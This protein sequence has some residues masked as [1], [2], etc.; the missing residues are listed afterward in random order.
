MSIPIRNLYYMLAY[1][2][3]RDDF[4]GTTKKVGSDEFPE[5]I[6]F[7]ATALAKSCAVLLRRGF[8]RGYLEVVEETSIPRG[9]IDFG[10]TI[11]K[12]TRRNG[13]VVCRVEE[14]T[15]DVLHNQILKTVIAKLIRTSDVRKET[16]KE[17]FKVLERMPGVQEISLDR[18]VFNRVQ[19]H[20]NNSYYLF[21][22]SVCQ[23]LYRNLLPDEVS[24]KYKFT[25]FD[26]TPQKM[27]TLFEKFVFKFLKDKKGLLD[28]ECKKVTNRNKPPQFKALDGSDPELVPNWKT[29]VVLDGV[30]RHVIIETK[31]YPDAKGHYH[32]GSKFISDHLMQLLAYLHDYHVRDKS[33]PKPTGILLY[34]QPEDGFEGGV[35][36]ICGYRIRV[37]ALDLSLEWRAIGDSLLQIANSN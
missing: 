8:D 17:L 30:D 21:L 7:L 33:R 19:I 27:G 12:C 34:A 32:G 22:L 5:G 37:T 25:G 35:Y 31:F 1:A 10:Q 2:W 9:K 23:F 26:L 18:G 6:E 24:G 29:D 4:P 11:G 20:R 36:E 15:H 28:F 16:R 14:F 13:K 3:G